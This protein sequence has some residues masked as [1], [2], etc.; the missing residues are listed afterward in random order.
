M[1]C[2]SYFPLLPKGHLLAVDRGHKTLCS[3]LSLLRRDTVYCFHNLCSKV[4][5]GMDT[6]VN[7]RRD[8]TNFVTKGRLPRGGDT[9]ALYQSCPV[10]ADTTVQTYWREKCLGEGYTLGREDIP[11]RRYGPHSVSYAAPF[12]SSVP[13]LHKCS[14]YI[15]Y[16]QICHISFLTAA[17]LYAC[18]PVDW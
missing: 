17:C 9:F 11:W 16:N 12:V 2:T 8:G 6:F 7:K 14:N 18:M 3:I 1:Q 15:I 5:S 10:V 4:F 13:S